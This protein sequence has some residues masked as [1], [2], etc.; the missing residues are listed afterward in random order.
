MIPHATLS[1]DA[2]RRITEQTIPRAVRTSAL[3]ALRASG[4]V[5]MFAGAPDLAS[6]R[7]RMLKGKLR[8]KAGTA[9]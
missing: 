7:K 5:G 8:G 2:R 9:G 4:M 3:D 6:S 1:K